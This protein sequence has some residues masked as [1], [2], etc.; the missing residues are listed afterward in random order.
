M[1]TAMSRNCFK[2]YDIFLGKW[3]TLT[4]STTATVTKRSN[5]LFP[6]K[7]EN[8]DESNNSYYYPEG[9]V[10][11]FPVIF[12]HILKIHPPQP[13]QKSGRHQNDSE[14]GQNFDDLIGFGGYVGK[15]NIQRGYKC[16][17]MRFRQFDYSSQVIVNIAE[18]NGRPFRNQR[19]LSP[20]DLAKH[21][22]L[23]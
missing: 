1:I 12:R 5:P 23:R 10:T 8:H 16:I 22:P 17:S 18:I 6:F 3:V 2:K 21:F 11:V 20:A 15:V 19:E 7:E 14:D 13:D 9:K 4:G